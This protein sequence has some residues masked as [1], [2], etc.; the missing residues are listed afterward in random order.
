MDLKREFKNILTFFE[1]SVVLIKKRTTVSYI[2]LWNWTRKR[3][4]LGL[5]NKDYIFWIL[6]W[7]NCYLV[8]ICVLQKHYTKIQYA[9][10]QQALNK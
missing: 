10:N 5:S 4:A 9:Q 8:K 2:G 7:K 3:K 1:S 6:L